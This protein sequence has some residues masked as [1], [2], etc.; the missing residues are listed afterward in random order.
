MEG[1]VLRSVERGRDL[2]RT[3]ART[4]ETGGW[5][6]RK[7]DAPHAPSA[8]RAHDAARQPETN[9]ELKRGLASKPRDQR[10]G[11]DR[12]EPFPEVVRQ[13]E[14][15]ERGPAL[16]RR[17]HVDRHRAHVDA[18]DRRE[19]P[20]DERHDQL[21][22][23][24]SRVER[25]VV[26]RLDQIKPRKDARDREG[27]HRGGHVPPALVVQPLPEP[28][29][30][31]RPERATRR[32]R[33][34]ERHVDHAPR[35]RPGDPLREPKRVRPSPPHVRGLPDPLPRQSRRRLPRRRRV[36]R[37]ERRRNARI[38]TVTTHLLIIH[39][40]AARTRARARASA[41]AAPAPR[42]H[43]VFIHQP[44]DAQPR[45]RDEDE[46]RAPPE[47]RTRVPAHALPKDHARVHD[48]AD[49]P[50]RVRSRRGRE[51]VARDGER[52]RE[53][54]ADGDAGQRAKDEELPKRRHEPRERARPLT[55]DDGHHEQVFATRDVGQ[56]ADDEARGEAEEEEC[57]GDL[58]A[59]LRVA[60]ALVEPEV[61][62]DRGEVRGEQVLIGEDAKHRGAEEEEA[63]GVRALRERGGEQRSVARA[64]RD[65]ARHDDASSET[66]PRRLSKKSKKLTVRPRAS[67]SPRASRRLRQVPRVQHLPVALEALV[68]PDVAQREVVIPRV[69]DRHDLQLHHARD[70]R[71]GAHAVPLHDRDPEVVSQRLHLV[72]VVRAA[73][74]EQL[75]ERRVTL[76]QHL[77]HAAPGREHVARGRRVRVQRDRHPPRRLYRHRTRVGRDVHGRDARA[78]A[79]G[80]GGRGREA[81]HGDG[82]RRVRRRRRRRRGGRLRVRVRVRGVR[83]GF[84]RRGRRRDAVVARRRAA[85]HRHER[86]ASQRVVDA[87]GRDRVDCGVAR[88]PTTAA[89]SLLLAPPRRDVDA[90][91]DAEPE[92]E[93]ERHHRPG[94]R[95]RGASGGGPARARIWRRCAV[96]WTE[97]AISNRLEE[98]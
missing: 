9:P 51:Q 34:H 12:P 41:V 74:P 52:E 55:E 93:G 30:E 75:H 64:L 15:R 73:L 43:R 58:S 16:V 92:P 84:Q 44:R 76:P 86:R 38:C 62:R 48:E 13:V 53:R 31:Y 54:A 96:R 94:H 69:L 26:V 80:G 67:Y 20:S 3:R 45:D 91:A 19:V 90:D 57:D 37:E 35:H 85:S 70:V 61:V 65:D 83:G 47:N 78:V 7:Y 17:V 33:H 95:R 98:R 79:R 27:A 42:F 36:R 59:E 81:V 72:A 82:E 60:L 56:H 24:P 68:L 28:P 89:G 2:R 71:D 29:P 5:Y 11:H 46:R 6:F 32:K 50:G 88:R 8:R 10:R 39:A 25:R 63:R 4:V 97:N 22:P 40:A 21:E 1:D 14:P 77:K 87:R 23:E 49:R 66:A 18:R